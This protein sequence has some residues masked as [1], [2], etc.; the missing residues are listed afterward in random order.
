MI[1]PF[2]L[3]VSSRLPEAYASYVRAWWG[4]GGLPKKKSPLSASRGAIDGC[5]FV[6]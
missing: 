4:S 1:L 3:S 2:F 5:H 6:F